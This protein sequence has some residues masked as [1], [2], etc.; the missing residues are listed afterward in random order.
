MKDN[1]VKKD[2]WVLLGSVVGFYLILI[3]AGWADAKLGL[4]Q[5]YTLVDIASL[6]VQVATAS[7]LAWIVKR[8]ALAQTLG[9]DFGKVFDVGWSKF[10]DKEKARWIIGA[11][12][13]I[14][15][16]VLFASK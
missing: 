15:T 8:L 1:S 7:A 13:V 14:F 12:L 3:G 16:S 2:V 4:T 5:A 10:D 9:K 6:A 11:F